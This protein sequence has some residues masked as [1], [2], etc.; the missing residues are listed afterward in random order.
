MT[1]GIG[2]FNQVMSTFT[3]FGFEIVQKLLNSWHGAICAL[4]ARASIFNRGENDCK[5]SRKELNAH[6]V[7]NKLY[8]HNAAFYL[9]N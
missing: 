8:R 7:S 6:I 3:C 9:D 5:K 4:S 1:F 2:E